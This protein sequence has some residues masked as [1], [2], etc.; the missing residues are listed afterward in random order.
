[1]CRCDVGGVIV[2]E[3]VDWGRRD[4]ERG[5]REEGGRMEEGAGDEESLSALWDCLLGIL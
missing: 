1:M 5:R 3:D 4:E 2:F